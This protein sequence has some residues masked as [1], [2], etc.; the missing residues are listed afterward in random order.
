MNKKVLG[1]VPLAIFILLS[2]FLYQGLFGNP[3][4]IQ[5]GRLGHT[6]PAFSLPDLMD[7][8]TT[9]T[10]KDLQ[11][12]VYLLNVWGTWCPTCL[13]ELGY[14]TELKDKG[15][16][17]VG[18]YY[19]QAYDPD[20]G[21]KFDVVAL[22]EEVNNML[23]RAGNPYAFNILDLNRSLALDLGVS[24]APETFLVDKAGKI[25]VH[26]TGDMNTRVWRTKFAPA[27]QELTL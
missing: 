17:I 20:F 27:I 11:G 22:R 5:T 18:L 16:K 12:D 24:G 10:D 13:A 3:R 9:W 7:E 1:L 14:L 23:G 2:V 25:L 19:D 21:D 8:Q 26:H 4:E 6:M 15:V